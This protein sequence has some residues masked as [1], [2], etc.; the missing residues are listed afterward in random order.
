MPI[1]AVC[2][3]GRRMLATGQLPAAPLACPN[4]LAKCRG[5]TGFTG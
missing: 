1:A 5:M 4:R 3:D 2:G